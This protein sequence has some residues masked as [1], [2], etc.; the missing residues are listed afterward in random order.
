MEKLVAKLKKKFPE[1]KFIP[2]KDLSIVDHTIHLDKTQH[3]QIGDCYACLVTE[4]EGPKF[5]FKDFDSVENVVEH[6]LK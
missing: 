1:A 5:G 2:S 4:Y 3:I 6:L